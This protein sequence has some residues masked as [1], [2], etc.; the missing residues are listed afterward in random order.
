MAEDMNVSEILDFDISE[1]HS[2]PRRVVWFLVLVVDYRTRVERRKTDEILRCIRMKAR[3]GR[4][5]ALLFSFRPIFGGWKRPNQDQRQER[6]V[7]EIVIGAVA[8]RGTE[9]YR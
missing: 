9:M 8:G 6:M 7:S 1:P 5:A 3:K 2:D 4:S